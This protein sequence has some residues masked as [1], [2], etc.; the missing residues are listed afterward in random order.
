[1]ESMLACGH[2]MKSQDELCIS[3]TSIFDASIALYMPCIAHG[4][5]GKKRSRWSFHTVSGQAHA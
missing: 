2:A 3:E 1:M 5:R 4:E